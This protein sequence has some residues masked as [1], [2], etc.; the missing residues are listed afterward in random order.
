MKE[1]TWDTGRVESSK[2]L[3]IYYDGPSFE[4][5]K[6]YFWK[7]YVWNNY[8]EN[9]ESGFITFEMGLIKNSD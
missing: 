7:A 9:C 4:S 2:S 8:G 5:R 3:N 1:I 6:Q